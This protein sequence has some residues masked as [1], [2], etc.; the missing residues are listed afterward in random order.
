MEVS[1]EEVNKSAEATPQEQPNPDE[2][3]FEDGNADFE[4]EFEAPSDFA[5]PPGGGFRYVSFCV[6]L[7]N[8]L[9]KQNHF[10]AH[11]SI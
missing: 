5:F 8:I 2:E 11:S 9:T 6:K 1:S 4:G 10:T 3:F 7:L